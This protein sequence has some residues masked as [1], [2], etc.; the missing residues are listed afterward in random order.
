[1]VFN[2]ITYA[3]TSGYCSLI[4]YIGAALLGISHCKPYHMK[5]I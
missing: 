3:E 1:V 5:I 4:L 2:N